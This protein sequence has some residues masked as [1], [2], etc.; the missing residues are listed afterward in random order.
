MSGKPLGE[1]G[2]E[3]FESKADMYLTNK[4]KAEGLL[5]KAMKKASKNRKIGDSWEKLQLLFGLFRDWLNGSYRQIPTKSIATAVI[6]I[7]YFVSPIDLVPDF[8]LGF[9][10]LDDAAVIGFVIKQINK[11]LVAYQVWKQHDQTPNELQP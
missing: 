11:D 5:R 6:A 2:F 8:I 1:K 9:G 4:E 10:L 7:I 3:K